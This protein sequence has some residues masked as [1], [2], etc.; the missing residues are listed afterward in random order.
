M[1]IYSVLLSLSFA[2]L[3]GPLSFSLAGVA[4]VWGW[5]SCGPGPSQLPLS[6]L[7]SSP[8][9]SSRPHPPQLAAAASPS[10]P[11]LLSPAPPPHPLPAQDFVPGIVSCGL[12][13]LP[14]SWMCSVRVS[15]P[16]VREDAWGW[17]GMNLGRGAYFP[18]KTLFLCFFI[19]LSPPPLH[20]LYLKWG[21]AGDWSTLN[22]RFITASSFWKLS[23][24]KEE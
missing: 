14:L 21:R 8:G 12:N 23:L 5:G 10:R 3:P 6:P 22:H 13:S 9:V 2:R 15:F 19:P 18:R 17:A 7:P 20:A 16:R 24:E 4:A 11:A 1:N